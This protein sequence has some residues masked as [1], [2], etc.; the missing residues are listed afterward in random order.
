MLWCIVS[1]GIF[2][3]NTSFLAHNTAF[4]HAFDKE[5][6]KHKGIRNII[7]INQKILSSTPEEFIGN[8][9]HVIRQGF[10]ASAY[11]FL[12]SLGIFV[13]TGIALFLQAVGKKKAG[14]KPASSN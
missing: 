6:Q 1:A 5:L 10:G 9:K 11:A 8:S 3:F 2:L 14:E 7:P 4:A 12:M 13:L